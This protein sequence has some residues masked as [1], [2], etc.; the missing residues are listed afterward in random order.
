MGVWD[1]PS[2]PCLLNLLG[3]NGEYAHLVIF[4]SMYFG[5][6][7]RIFHKM[8]SFYPRSY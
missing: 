1:D 8:F 6:K 7:L 2:D 4:I 3:K 5:P